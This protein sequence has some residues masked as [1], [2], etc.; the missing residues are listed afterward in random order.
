MTHT[1]E[2]NCSCGHSA[3]WREVFFGADRKPFAPSGTFKRYAP[4]T[5]VHVKH[6]K[7]VLSILPDEKT[8]IGTVHARVVAIADNVTDVFFQGQDMRIGRASLAGS[9]ND[10]TL[11][12]SE[13]GVK[14]KLPKTL[15]RGEE[16]DLSVEYKLVNPKAGIYFTG[17]TGLYPDKPTQIWTQGQD[18]D[19]Q[20]WFP[21]PLADYPN[22]KMTS[23]IL[24]TVPERFTALS[25]GRMVLETADAAAGTKTFHW[26]HDKPHVSY[27]ITLVIG[28]FAKIE[29]SYKGL[30]V[31]CY[32]HPNQLAEGK[33]Y[34]RG[35]A[36]LVA[37]YSR[38]Y[39]I[40]YPWNGSYSQVL[41]Q[42]FIFGGMENTTLST[43]TDRILSPDPDYRKFQIRLN[44][45]E[46][47]HQWWGDLVTC[48]DWSHAWLNEG[49]A[50]YGEVEAMEHV[51]G[52]K[53]RD[54][55]VK[56]L[57]DTYFAEDRRYR[58]PIV[59]NVYR[60]PIDLFDRHLYQKGGLVRHM[61]RYLLGDEGYYRSLKTFLTDHSFGVADTHDLIKAI[62]KTT[63][64]NLREFFD[65]WVFGAGFPEYKVSF[66]WDEK[67]K[68]ATVKV[69][70]TQKV[71]E[72]TGL[73][74]MPIKFSF[75]LADGTTKDFTVIV[76]DKDHSFSFHVDSKPTMFRFDPENW[77]LKKLDLTGVP[78][79]MLIH[80]LANDTEVMGRVHAAQALT[81]VGG[82]E[83]VEAL[84]DAMNGSIHW[85]IQVECANGL[86]SIGTPAA[87]EALKGAIAN[88][89]TRVRRAVVGALGNFKDETVADLLAGII[90]GGTE[91]S[92]SVMADAA[93]AL[94]KTKSAK[95]LPVLK[96]A[97]GIASW[98]E[99]VRI[100][101]LNGL[102][103]LGDDSVVELASD[104]AK[105]GKPAHSRP[106]A[107]SALGKLAKKFAGAVETLHRLAEDEETDQFM[108]RMALIGALGEAKKPESAAVLNAI[109][110]TATDGRV[111]RAIE[112]T[113][114]ELGSKSGGG[115]D[116]SE[117]QGKV[118]KLTDQ[119]RA[120][121]EQQER[122]ALAAGTTGK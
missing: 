106:A 92:V 57:A 94:G 18:E 1:H 48:R 88:I 99:T 35:T 13:F 79:G 38:L 101:A 37:L 105:G 93:V 78:K 9:A 115:A 29:E 65:Q 7:L 27:L 5:P 95:A 84:R 59:T 116:T 2:H 3:W 86:G 15:K 43:I 39:G 108:L 33:D 60:E 87:R 122:A 81:K 6:V 74:S 61:L 67:G 100:G 52:K 10:L 20:F 56:G 62:E 91:K 89:D 14:V 24:V 103:E 50:T 36:D 53:E 98:N 11:E 107:I 47:C 85:G 49:G 69:S 82:L 64:R 28:E 73:F 113:L 120:L 110:R 46:L 16:I 21:V 83:A 23:E 76:S 55:Y 80:Q 25:N 51:Y 19:A 68:V 30:P 70:Q 26:L 71:D 54:Y 75:G 118:D 40:E 4:D 58:R 22:H 90:T 112:E 17:A 119:V 109:G 96:Q 111:K 42:D 121:T 77:V 34:A 63:G 12:T 8:I 31:I 104:W 72:M 44:G 45:H 114:A 32:V 41:V 66:I 117:L 97:L 102:A